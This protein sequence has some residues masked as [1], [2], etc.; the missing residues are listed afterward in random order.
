[1]LY[2]AYLFFVI[3]LVTAFFGF[4]AVSVAAAGVAK[5]LFYIFAGMFVVMLVSGLLSQSQAR[6]TQRT[7][8]PERLL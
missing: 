5:I 4:G 1:M 2:W 8:S 3:A 6:A 7:E